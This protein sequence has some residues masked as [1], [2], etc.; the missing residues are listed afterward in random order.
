MTDNEIVKALE[1]CKSL[2]HTECACCPLDKNKNCIEDLAGFALSLITRQKAENL[3]LTSRLTSLQNDLTSAKAEIERL[4]AKRMEIPEVKM[5]AN[6]IR[7]EAIKEFARKLK[8]GV[9]QETG[10]IRCADIDNLVEEM[11]GDG[12]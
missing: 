10:I 1:F 6:E 3:N 4:K 12:K 11:V 9:P 5:F 8:C 2:H 7:A